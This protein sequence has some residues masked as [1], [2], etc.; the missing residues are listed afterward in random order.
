MDGS[1]TASP[2]PLMARLRLHDPDDPGDGSSSN[3]DHLRLHH[4]QQQQLL[5]HQYLD[6]DA[7]H[8]DDDEPQQQQQLDQQSS[9][10]QEATADDGEGPDWIEDVLQ[11]QHKYSAKLDF[12]LKLGYTGA[13][14]EAAI[15]KLG[16]DADQN[17]LLAELIQL[18]SLQS[19]QRRQHTPLTQHHSVPLASSAGHHLRQHLMPPPTQPHVGPHLQAPHLHPQLHPYSSSPPSLQAPVVG[20]LRPIVVDGSNVAMT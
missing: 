2:S 16:L 13:Q 3:N 6:H 7:D 18:S 8:V 9:E 11:Q 19:V 4:H 20:A 5:H 12:G 17:Q 1:V 14:V 15:A 10:H